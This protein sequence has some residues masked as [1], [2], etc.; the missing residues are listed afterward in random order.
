MFVTSNR[1]V[2]SSGLI[3][4]WVATRETTLDRWSTPVNLGST[5]NTQYN[6]G[7]PA[8]SCDATTLYFYSDRPR[9]DGSSA[10]RDL[11]VTT[12]HKIHY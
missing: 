5:I 3:D 1:P 12:R 7:G 6:D 9:P 11:Y 10:G 4:L 2:G 8:L